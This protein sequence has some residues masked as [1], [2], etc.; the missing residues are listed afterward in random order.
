[1]KIQGLWGDEMFYIWITTVLAQF[2][3]NT[4][5][6]SKLGNLNGWIL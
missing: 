5:K 4:L 6:P 1:M 3:E 2:C